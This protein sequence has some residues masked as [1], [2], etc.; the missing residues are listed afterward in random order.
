[1]MTTESNHHPDSKRSAHE[2]RLLM[3]PPTRRDAEAM[4]KVL[5]AAGINCTTCPT[6]GVLCD[7]MKHGVGAIIVPEESLT[8]DAEP[9]LDLVQSQP[10]WSD[11]PVII[12]S[13]SGVESLIL[14]AV[15][16]KL[17]AISVLERPVRINTL[18]SV[19]RT[20]LQARERQYQ[21]R[22]HLEELAAARGEA[23]RI[24]RMKDE[25][26]AT[27]SHE[28]R[29]PLNAILGWTQ[30]LKKNPSD[31]DDVLEGLEVIERNARAQ[32]QIIEDLL[33]MSRII[34]GKVAL[35]VQRIELAS[36][37]RI[38]VETVKPAA[39]AKGIR[40]RTI[41]DSPSSMVSG[42]A[43]RLQQ[44]FWN[45]LSNA[46]K[47]TP[48][49]GQVQVLLERVDSQVEVSVMDTGEGINPQFIP[50]VFDRFR[51]ADA[52]TT[53]RHGGLG[54]GLSIVKQLVELHGG[55][56]RVKSPGAG[57]GSTFI[58]S[59][60]MTIMHAEP[61]AA[62]Q[63]RHPTAEPSHLSLETCTNL[64]GVRV[65]LVD[66]EPDARGLLKRL[67]EDCHAVVST[68]AS[69]GEAY[70]RVLSDRPNVLVSDIGMPG[71]D[72][73]SLIRRVRLLGAERGGNVPAVALTAYA[74]AEDRVKA[75][76]SGFQTHLAKPVEPA[77]L[78]AMIASL[79]KSASTAE[80]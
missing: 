16:A 19:A 80:V 48:R 11:L 7:E 47:F 57:K 13:R 73:Y 61:H 12:L 70:Q 4:Q 23:E 28:L 65:L 2:M 60:P 9:L 50:H 52:S 35:S 71:E 27:L 53:R 38:A 45:L 29:T 55:T 1:M 18:I 67:L 17:G 62:P 24:N 41:L 6:V 36:V 40:L 76:M 54:L 64:D 78:I 25:F 51:Q 58:V 3:I 21:V 44:V 37:V 75:I 5:G 69:A 77:E 49:D 56:V 42:D 59:L 14:S 33:D 34:S 79:A 22:D 68:A 26:L 63:R 20:A 74:R 8:T 15:M 10:V 46:V 72:G 32:T 30:I 31:P 66:D 39:D 43:N